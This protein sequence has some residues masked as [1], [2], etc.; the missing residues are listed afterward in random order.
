M[1]CLHS[2]GWVRIRIQFG[3][4]IPGLEE[5]RVGI[6]QN[7]FRTLNVPGLSGHKN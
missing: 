1:L 5:F 3:L 2:K 6:P 7:W 4:G